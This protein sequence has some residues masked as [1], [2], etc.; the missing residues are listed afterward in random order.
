MA[1]HGPPFLFLT[2]VAAPFR[3]PSAAAKIARI[4]DRRHSLSASSVPSALKSPRALTA[5]RPPKPLHLHRRCHT[6]FTVLSPARA[7]AGAAF[8][9]SAAASGAL[10]HNSAASIML[11]DSSFLSA[12]Q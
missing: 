8:T 9:G 6:T 5:T 10:A 1:D 12:A 3:A 11:C 4:P 7:A 2:L